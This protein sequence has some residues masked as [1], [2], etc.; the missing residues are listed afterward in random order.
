[1]SCGQLAGVEIKFVVIDCFSIQVF[2]DDF[3]CFFDADHFM[4]GWYKLAEVDKLFEVQS[5]V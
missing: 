3:S 4:V 1:M 5:L 2:L